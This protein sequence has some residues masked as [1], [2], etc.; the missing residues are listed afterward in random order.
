MSTYTMS[1]VRKAGRLW[2]EMPR[3]EVADHM[4][5]AASTITRWSS[6]GLISTETNHYRNASAQ[7]VRRADD[8]YDR[9]S[10]R[11]VAD[12][13]DVSKRTLVNWKQKGWI[14]TEK[15]WH[16]INSGQEK[17][18]NPRRAVELYHSE[19]R[20]QQEVADRMDIAP[21]TVSN[22]LRQYRN[23]EL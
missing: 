2:D 23:G 12:I 9:M 5:V 22:Y 4:G 10:L 1:D 19:D 18:A 11:E 16:K 13:V 21:S 6:M 8:L 14:S 17:K 15:D 7:A 3:K 20:T